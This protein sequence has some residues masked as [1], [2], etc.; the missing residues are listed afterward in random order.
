MGRTV[1]GDGWM[2]ACTPHQAHA[3]HMPQAVRYS[4]STAPTLLEPL[5]TPPPAPPCSWRRLLPR[6]ARL[7]HRPHRKR[8]L[9]L[10]VHL[11][12]GLAGLGYVRRGGCSGSGQ[13]E[14]AACISQPAAPGPYRLPLHAAATQASAALVRLYMLVDAIP[15]P[16][17]LFSADAGSTPTMALPGCTQQHVP[18][19]VRTLM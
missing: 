2:G 9:Q 6:A 15:R 19:A 17:F 16:A 7:A 10:P 5:H 14:R 8:C 12:P 1:E 18:S 13:E 11:G 3:K 4:S